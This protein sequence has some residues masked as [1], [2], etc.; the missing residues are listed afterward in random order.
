MKPPLPFFDTLLPPNKKKG[1][2]QKRLEARWRLLPKFAGIIASNPFGIGTGKEIHAAEKQT[3][4]V[5]KKKGGRGDKNGDA[6]P[7]PKTPSDGQKEEKHRKEEAAGRSNNKGH[8]TGK[9]SDKSEDSHGEH[10]KAQKAK[11]KA[12]EQQK[13]DGGGPEEKTTMHAN[14]ARGLA[15]IWKELNEEEPQTDN[16]S[17]DED[18]TQASDAPK[19]EG[20]GIVRD[21]SGPVA[22][23]VAYSDSDSDEPLPLPF[24]KQRDRGAGT[25]S[26]A[27]AEEASSSAPEGAG[28][29]WRWPWRSASK[30]LPEEVS[31]DTKQTGMVAATTAAA[32][33][34]GRRQMTAVKDG[35]A[36]ALLLKVLLVALLRRFQP[37]A[38]ASFEL[39]SLAVPL[40]DLLAHWM[41]RPPVMDNFPPAM[42]KAARDLTSF[43]VP[44]L[45]S[46]VVATAAALVV[47]R[48]PPRPVRRSISE[49]VLVLREM[50]EEEANGQQELP[51]GP[52]LGAPEFA[53]H[54]AGHRAA[55]H[56]AELAEMARVLDA[57]GARLPP[58]R[59]DASQAELLR[60]GAS[61]GLLEASSPEERAVA[62][63]AAAQ[64]IMATLQWRQKR[65]FMTPQQ[66]HPWEQHIQWHGSDEE[67]HPILLVHLARMCDDC[68]SAEHAQQAADAVISQVE[69]AVRRRLDNEVGP[70]QL[71]A[72]VDARGASA[73]QVTRKVTLI[74]ETALALNQH[75]P[76]RLHRL[77]VV[78]LPASLAWVVDTIRPMLHPTTATNLR[79]CEAD[80]SSVPL[81]P[82]VL[83]PPP[84]SPSTPIDAAPN[85]T[86]TE[87]DYNTPRSTV[88]LPDV[89]ELTEMSQRALSCRTTPG[90]LGEAATAAGNGGALS[91]RK[92][93]FI[94]DSPVTPITEHRTSRPLRRSASWRSAGSAEPSP[95]LRPSLKRSS[96]SGGA[97]STS[98][99]R[100]M[101]AEAAAHRPST[102]RR[103]SSF[104]KSHMLARTFSLGDILADKEALDLAE[105]EASCEQKAQQ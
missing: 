61:C 105:I 23:I 5:E 9:D 8:H 95:R 98:N 46:R 74:K 42:R 2:H 31:Q 15:G 80:D 25:A 79:M 75:Y 72:V 59:F 54:L 34:L 77:W 24:Q 82:H 44:L 70:D 4:D 65:K 49:S 33:R 89:P 62:I 87:S 53:S 16:R 88:T 64:K 85:G 97:T 6:K 93:V 18:P 29:K 78:G 68:Q 13:G 1:D 14:V 73:L 76:G 30:R 48:K 7:N 32:Q 91:A 66:L 56:A 28:K 84:D 11:E 71:V 52:L 38:V 57:H 81:P 101:E 20:E 94:P 10:N 103:S 26:D 3:S 96:Y 55:L 100:A 51:G 43:S 39:L 104:P 35:S 41:R 63:E 40:P 27:E 19:S 102:L 69:L 90:S 17:S 47:P 58:D 22:R 12:A 99:S 86:D 45:V 21:D 37:K 50:A 36:L 83:N 92:R 60:Y 67:G